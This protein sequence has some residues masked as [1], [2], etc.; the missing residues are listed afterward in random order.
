MTEKETTNQ[1]TAKEPTRDELIA[2]YHSQIEL[3]R[4]RTELAELHARAVKA[5]AQRV[6]ASVFLAQ[7]DA[8]NKEAQQKRNNSESSGGEKTTQDEKPNS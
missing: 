8:A 2:W 5:E 4:L 1:D 7:V 6:E 3:A